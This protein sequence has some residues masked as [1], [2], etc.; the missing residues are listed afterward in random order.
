MSY[1]LNVLSAPS[2][3]AIGGMAPPMYVCGINDGAWCDLGRSTLQSSLSP[4]LPFLASNRA[5]QRTSFLAIGFL[6]GIIT[7][8]GTNMLDADLLVAGG[9]MAGVCAAIA[10]ARQGLKVV[11]C[12]DRSVLGGNASS[13][14]RMHIVGADCHG[15]RRGWRESG[16]IEEMRL[17]DSARN[18]ERCYPLWDIILYEKVIAEPNITLLLDT[19]VVGATVDRAASAEGAK[20]TSIQRPQ[21]TPSLYE[22]HGLPGHVT[23]VRAIRH[24]TEDEF[25]IRAKF[26][27]DC[28]GDGRLGFEAGADFRIGRENVEMHCE[29]LAQ[30]AS[31]V[32]TLGSSILLTSRKLDHAVPFVPPP[33]ARKFTAEN[34]GRYRSI[35]SWE[36]GF[37]WIE[38]GGHL[39]TIKDNCTTIRHELYRIALGLW[40]YVKNSG[41][42]DSANWTL[43][44]IGSLPGKRESRRFLGPHILT[45]HDVLE[46]RQHADEVAYGGWAIDLHP[47]RGI[48]AIDE[49]PFTPT[50]APHVYGI[51]L[52]CYFSR[53]IDNLFFAGRNISATHVAFASTR[54]MATCAVGGEA[55]GFAAAYCA[56][57]NITPGSLVDDPTHVRSLRQ[58]MLRADVTLLRQEPAP[59]LAHEARLSA[60]SAAAGSPIE[61]IRDGATRDEVDPKTGALVQSHGWRS[62]RMLPGAPQWIDL[63][64]E[65]PVTVTEIHLWFDTGF[66]RELVLSPS[67]WP[68]SRPGADRVI[69][70]PQPE[71]VRNYRIEI[72]GV[73]AFSV[74][75]NHQRK[76]VHLLD[77]PMDV[78]HIRIWVSQTNG[79]EEARIF[80]VRVY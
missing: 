35:G 22:F 4:C 21:R 76:R 18:P 62:N 6:R 66:T 23:S 20:P 5:A 69:R 70:G 49:P 30:Q 14:I 38:W 78:T 63:K 64:W 75:D 34:L 52:R 44:W 25:I 9:G 48:D 53:N 2:A 67:D 40:D 27:A 12:Q 65:T 15:H 68:L 55:V 17:E 57:H 1:K 45:E 51:P 8:M 41:K 7:C 42:F 13:E 31:D 16:L 80:E 39:D 26:Y 32:H 46:A 33:W 24:Q 58:Q 47:V 79:I 37:W 19:D 74:V 11:L 59:N 36:Y 56:A 10:A 3:C 61:K 50:H 71:T 72:D 73:A 28:T 43:D 29:S 60:S 54:V 77:K